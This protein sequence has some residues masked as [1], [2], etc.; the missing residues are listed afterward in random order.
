MM[1]ELLAAA[2]QVTVPQ[3]ID[4]AFNPGSIAPSAGRPGSR[5]RG[6]AP[7]TSA[8][9]GD[10]AEV[11]RQIDGWNRRSDAD[12]TGALAYYAFKRALGNECGR[13]VEPPAGLKD[14]AILEALHRGAAWLRSGFGSV[15]VPYG[16][17]FRVGREG[18]DRSWPVGGGTLK[19][20]GD[21]HAARDQLRALARRQ[22][23]DR[24]RRP[25]RRPRSSS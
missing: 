4:I 15:E 5:R 13:Q 7:G 10:A 11:F 25:D 17:Y 12:S 1:N 6:R 20:P 9:S 3:A 24:P 14:E 8:R 22:V 2:D 18:G 16:R 23:D 19:R 21:G